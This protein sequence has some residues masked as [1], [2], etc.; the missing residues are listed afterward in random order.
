MTAL[1]RDNE[2]LTDLLLEALE[3]ESPVPIST[4][5]LS[6]KVGHDNYQNYSS[7]LRMLNR[8]AKRGE[9]EKIRLEDMRSCYW[10]RWPV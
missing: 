6:A 1:T 7:V 5:A 9:V 4:L 8:L 10:R 3:R 2:I